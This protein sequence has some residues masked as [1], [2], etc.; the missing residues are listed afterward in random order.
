[1][2]QKHSLLDSQTPFVNQTLDLTDSIR[3]QCQILEDGVRQGTQVIHLIGQR[4]AVS[5]CPT[6]GFGL[7]DLRFDGV[8]FCWNSPIAGPVHPSL[9]NL[10][11]PDGLG[12]L[13]GFDEAMVRCGLRNVG[14]PQLN[15][16]G[17]LTDPIHG[18]IANIPASSVTLEFDSEDSSVLRLT[19]VVSD[20]LFHFH[21]LQLTVEMEL[22]FREQS[23]RVSDRVENLGGRPAEVCLMHHWNFGTPVF[24]KGSRIHSKISSVVARDEFSDQ[25]TET[26]DE[27]QAPGSASAESVFFFEPDADF[28]DG[29][30]VLADENGSSAVRVSFPLEKFPFWTLWKNPVAEVDGFAIGLEPGTC[31]PDGKEQIA[32][33]GHLLVLQQG[34][35]YETYSKLEIAH[36]D[37]KKVESWQAL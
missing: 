4:F 14:P 16:Q 29:A 34:E 20:S 19:G 2:I 27:I 35:S 25:S 21:R 7:W 36:Q 30:I 28:E 8:P 31:Y 9:V 32:K 33:K 24:G 22:N 6:R 5:V 11:R 3:V 18:N 12:W 37:S 23:L 15:E 1:M 26:W 10:Y 17:Q 13:E